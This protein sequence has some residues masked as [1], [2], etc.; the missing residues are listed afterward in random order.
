MTENVALRLA[1]LRAQLA[2]LAGDRRAP[3]V[4]AALVS[5]IAFSIR[6]DFIRYDHP[7]EN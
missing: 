1:S 5:L 2:R 4:L 3:L 6:S 7:L